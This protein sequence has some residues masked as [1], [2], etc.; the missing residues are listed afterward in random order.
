[1][2]KGKWK[3]KAILTPAPKPYILQV[4]KKQQPRSTEKS[5]EKTKEDHSSVIFPCKYP[6]DF[7]ARFLLSS[8]T[9][10]VI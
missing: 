1:M 5:N 9:Q 6:S 4:V 8:A 7:A 2:R 10:P 3:K